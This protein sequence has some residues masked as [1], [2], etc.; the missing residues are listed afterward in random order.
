MP[1]LILDITLNLLRFIGITRL[2]FFLL[3][4]EAY[5]NTIFATQGEDNGTK[6]QQKEDV[7]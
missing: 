3:L 6:K 4:S 2:P 1:R 5:V 7:I